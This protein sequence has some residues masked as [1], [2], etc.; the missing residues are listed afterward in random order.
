MTKNTVSEWPRYP[1][2][3]WRHLNR[4]CPFLFL[5]NCPG[6]GALKVCVNL[7]RLWGGICAKDFSSAICHSG[8]SILLHCGPRNSLMGMKCDFLLLVILLRWMLVSYWNMYRLWSMVW[9]SISAGGSVKRVGLEYYI[10]IKCLRA[11]ASYPA[12]KMCLEWRC[13]CGLQGNCLFLIMVFK[14]SLM[15]K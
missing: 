2:Q 9:Y 12:H 10:L 3:S 5:Y 11:G 14:C 4:R 8:I 1:R 7:A 15:A 13:L 6:T